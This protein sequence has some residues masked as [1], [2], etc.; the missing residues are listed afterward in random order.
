M[1]SLKNSALLG[2]TE[3]LRIGCDVITCT[4]SKAPLHSFW[5]VRSHEVSNA[6]PDGSTKFASSVASV[7]ITHVFPFIKSYDRRIVIF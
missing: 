7:S 1:P 5:F 6:Q 4:T 3:N 2:S